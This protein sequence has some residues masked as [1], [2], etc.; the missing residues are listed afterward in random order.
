MNSV[1]DIRTE[2]P[3]YLSCNRQ[4][5]P[6]WFGETDRRNEE[7]VKILQNFNSLERSVRKDCRH[8]FTVKLELA[9]NSTI[10][11]SKIC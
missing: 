6:A 2:V 9:S 11:Y 10:R 7:I 4:R 3:S 5:F 8:L 1:E